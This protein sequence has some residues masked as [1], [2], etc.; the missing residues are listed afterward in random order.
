MEI[1]CPGCGADVNPITAK[2][3]WDDNDERHIIC[4][5]CLRSYFEDLFMR[6]DKT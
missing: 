2:C 4:P 6:K 3:K 1:I 5:K